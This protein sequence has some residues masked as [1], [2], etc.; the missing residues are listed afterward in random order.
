MTPRELIIALEM[1]GERLE[2]PVPKLCSRAKVNRAT[3]Q[4]IKGEHTTPLHST[5]TRLCSLLTALE[6]RP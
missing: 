4:R 2:I 3:W 1:Q 5:Y 6:Q